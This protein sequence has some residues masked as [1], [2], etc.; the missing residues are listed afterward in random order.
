MKKIRDAIQAIIEAQG[1]T[2]YRSVNIE[3]LNQWAGTVDL[4]DGVGVL[5]NMPTVSFDVGAGST[6]LGTYEIEVFYLMLSP[7]DATGSQTDSILDIL[8]PLALELIDKLGKQIVTPGQ[9]IEDYSLTGVETLKLSKEV[10]TGWQVNVNVPSFR[11]AY[12][13]V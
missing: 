4:S 13:C 3:D 10:L 2:F 6:T 5:T 11:E 1:L 12:Y 8:E 7:I 9:M